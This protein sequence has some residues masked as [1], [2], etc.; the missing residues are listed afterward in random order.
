LDAEATG[1]EARWQLV[2]GALPAVGAPVV[3]TVDGTDV[4]V[5]ALGTKLVAFDDTCTHRMCPLSEGVIDETS[6]TCPCHKSRFDLTTGQPLNGPA[7][8]PIRIRQVSVD[9]SH[10]LIE[11]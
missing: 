4:A 10:L 5:V 2:A 1:T 6:V 7:T 11:R 9:G 8:D 3:V